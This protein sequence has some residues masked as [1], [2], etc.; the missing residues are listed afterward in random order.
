[1]RTMAAMACGVLAILA[2]TAAFGA[3]AVRL[4]P[5]VEVVLPADAPPALARAVEDLRRDLEKVLGKPSPLRRAAAEVTGETAI[6]VLPPGATSSLARSDIRGLE[7]HGVFTARDERGRPCVVLQGADLRGAIYAV[8][9]FSENFLGV[10]PLWIWA[11]WSPQTRETIDVPAAPLLF[12]PPAVRWRAWF[13]ND[14]DLFDAWIRKSDENYDAVFETMLRLKLNT[15]EGGLT[16]AKSWDTPGAAGREALHARDRGLAITGH[17]MRPFG[18][19]LSQWDSYWRKIRK[20][21]PPALAVKNVEA[22]KEFW[23]YHIDT[24]LKNHIE[25]VWLVAF[26]GNGDIP[27]WETFKDAPAEPAARAA[28]IQSMLATQIDL[29]KQATGE[30]HPLMRLTLYNENSDLVAAGLLKLPA[31]PSL[32]WT[33]VAARRDHYPPPDLLATTIPAGQPVGYYMNFQF[34]STGSH[35]AQAEGPWKMEANYRT[36]AAKADGPPAFSVVNAGNIREHLLELS[37]NAA[38][39]WN[40]EAYKTDAFLDGFCRAYFG[41]ERAGEAAGLYRAF[42]NAYWCPRKSDLP[43][44][45]RQYVFQDQRYARAITTLAAMLA[46]PTVATPLSERDLSMPG[47]YYRIVPADNGAADQVG[48]IIAGTEASVAR[49]QEV[50]RQADALLPRLPQG[51]RTFFNDNLRTQA[52]FMLATTQTLNHLAKAYAAKG[53]GRADEAKKQLDAARAAAAALPAILKEAEHGRFSAWYASDR[54]FNVRG[55]IAAVNKVAESGQDAGQIW[56]FTDKGNNPFDTDFFVCGHAVFAN[57]VRFPRP[58]NQAGE[59]FYCPT[60]PKGLWQQLRQ[61]QDVATETRPPFNLGDNEPAYYR[62]RFTSDKEYWAAFLPH[63]DFMRQ[64]LLDLRNAVLKDEY[65]TRDM[66]TWIKDDARI[67]KILLNTG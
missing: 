7:S 45:D 67:M 65:R 59:W 41:A 32:I 21:E 61:A 1:M 35:L 50:V 20:Q 39:M 64:F 48:A 22:L 55:V 62:I 56:N 53:A 5:G 51:S 34:T 37:A 42:F 40:L 14:R 30:G 9:T 43:G 25:A 8:Y 13:P 27:F 4:K 18:S 6:I 44:F 24:T 52:R 54:L 57:K 33:F 49:W 23:K 60:L 16:D 66:P 31:E 17:H 63:N 58:V 29:L 3:E 12:P 38:M 10:P 11:S 19:S 28:V 15:L 36:V 46:K 26:R 47:R 2:A